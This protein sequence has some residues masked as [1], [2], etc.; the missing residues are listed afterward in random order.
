MPRY[1]VTAPIAGTQSVTVVADDEPSAIDGAV[2]FFSTVL[3][4]SITLNGLSILIDH[5]PPRPSG[6]TGPYHPD[7][8]LANT[9]HHYTVTEWSDR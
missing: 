1:T 8:D 9:D 5:D 4:A 6:P 3:P 7:D 2:L